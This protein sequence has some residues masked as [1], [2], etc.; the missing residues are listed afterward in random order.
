MVRM[1][2]WYLGLHRNFIFR[3]RVIDESIY[4]QCILKAAKY[5]TINVLVCKANS[6]KLWM[7]ITW[8]PPPPKKRIGETKRGWLFIR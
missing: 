7:V 4:K 5:F 1:G 3:I 8:Q 6:T 2:I